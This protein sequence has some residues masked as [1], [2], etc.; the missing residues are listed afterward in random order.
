MTDKQIKVGDVVE[1]RLAPMHALVRDSVKFVWTMSD[2]EEW[3]TYEPLSLVTIIALDVPTD[4]T[5]DDLRVLADRFE[6][7]HFLTYG[8]ARH[9]V[10]HAAW[11]FLGDFDGRTHSEIKDR[12]ADMLHRAGWR[13]GMT[14]EDAARMLAEVTQ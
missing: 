13:P 7:R 14:A 3:Q 5:A 8:D 4:A 12:V 9:E 2:A 1:W 10:E 6:V 11:P